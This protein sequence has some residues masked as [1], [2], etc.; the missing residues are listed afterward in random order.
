MIF[1]Y[2]FRNT[3]KSLCKFKLGESRTKYLFNGDFLVNN[4]CTTK[5]PQNLPIWAKAVETKQPFK[6]DLLIVQKVHICL[7]IR[8]KFAK[9]M[10]T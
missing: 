8:E 7:C 10:N 3:A 4:N 6:G 5:K 9:L 2:L 1:V